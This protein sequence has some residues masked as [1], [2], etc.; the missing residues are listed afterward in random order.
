MNRFKDKVGKHHAAILELA[1]V[2]AD[3]E[4]GDGFDDISLET[5]KRVQR[6]IQEMCDEYAALESEL[7]ATLQ[8]QGDTNWLG[9]AENYGNALNAAGWAFLENCPEKSVLLFNNVKPALRAAILE[10]GRRVS[11]THPPKPVVS[12]VVFNVLTRFV[13]TTEDEGTTDLPLT[14]LDGLVAFG[15]LSKRHGGRHG[16]VYGIT[17]LGE[18][19]LGVKS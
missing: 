10:Y 5:I 7:E 13:E 18:A 12:D 9:D 17:E 6:D 11:D 4:D 3:V 1:G 2:V 14:M 8:Q 15:Y 16:N 19:A